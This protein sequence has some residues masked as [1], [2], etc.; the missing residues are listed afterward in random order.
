[1]IGLHIVSQRAPK[2]IH[3]DENMK[4]KLFG[5]STGDTPVHFLIACHKMCKSRDQI[6]NVVSVH[7][8]VKC[9]YLEDNEQCDFLLGKRNSIQLQNEECESLMLYCHPDLFHQCKLRCNRCCY[10]DRNSEIFEMQIVHFRHKHFILIQITSFVL[11][12]NSTL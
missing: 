9:S 2:T 12:L 1:M 5:Q 6:V 11:V 7:N 8:H 3:N 10:Y 4:C